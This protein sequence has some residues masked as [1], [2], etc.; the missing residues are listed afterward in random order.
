[1]HLKIQWGEKRKKKRYASTHTMK[2]H[3]FAHQNG[4]TINTAYENVTLLHRMDLKIILNLGSSI[5]MLYKA[6]SSSFSF[7]Y[8]CYIIN[9]GGDAKGAYSRYSNIRIKKESLEDVAAN[10]QGH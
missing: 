5:L 9:I 2:P 8:M 6:N 3:G 1:M 10:V 4:N 7:G